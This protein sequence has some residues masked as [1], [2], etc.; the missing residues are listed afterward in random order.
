MGWT[1][2]DKGEGDNDIQSILFQEYLDVLAE[3]INGKNCVL[4]GLAVTGAASMTPSVAKGAVLSNRVMF[5]VAAST[6]TIG[7]ADATNPRIDL[8]VVNS[9]GTLA[10]RAGTAAATPKPPARSTDDVVIAAVYVPAT[11]TTIATSQITDMRMMREGGIVIYR[12]SGNETT[13]TTAAAIGMLNKV[14]S[15]VT[16]PN[17][18]FSA[19]KIL[20]VRIGGNLLL[21]SGTPTVRVAVLYGG[22]TLFSDISGASTAD[23]DRAAFFIEFD[24]VAVASNDQSLSG[25]LGMGIIAAK[26]APTTGIGD[27]W[28]TAANIGPISGSSAVDS[29]AANR[30]LSVQ[31]TMSVSNAANELI[32]K[33]ATVE[34]L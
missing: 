20:R 18:L 32:V 10:V 7:T 13:N 30:L 17:G 8:I 4:S 34:L 26:T 14:N 23:A 16:I 11:D 33:T 2:P 15:G 22:T 31:L 6:V 1:I 27:A 25:V 29:D 5:A 28:S 19:G 24:L 12:T 21:N 3:G 9:S